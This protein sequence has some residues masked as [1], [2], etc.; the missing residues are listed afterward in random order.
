[1]SVTFARGFAASGVA[2][3]LK[4]NGNLD[5]ALVVNRGP[6]EAAAAVFTTNRAKANPIIWSQRAVAD[7]RARAVLLNSG[8]ANCYT[9]AEGFQTTHHSAERVAHLLELSAADV[10]VCSTGM[11]G[12]QLDRHAVLEGIELAVGALSED[13]SLNPA[14]AIMTTDSVPK[15]ATRESRTGWRIG[16]IAKG[17]GMLAPN[18]ATMLVVITTDAAV[19]ADDLQPALEQAVRVTFNRLDA[20]GCTSTNDQVTLL[21]SGRSGLAPEADDF[22]ELLTELCRDLAEQLIADAEGASHTIRIRVAGAATESDAEAIARTL[23]RNSLFKTAIYGND[24]NWGRILAAI[25]VA[26]VDFDPMAVSVSINGVRIAANG[27]PDADPATV[28][29]TQREVRIDIELASGSAEIELLTNDLTE[30][31]VVENSA[32]SS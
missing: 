16:G 17:A 14:L 1:M 28:D 27:A 6:N 11:I 23:A 15:H 2:A 21:A 32:Y 3:G 22:Q 31:Y 8:G 30:K 29:L 19:A 18:L 5:L 9:G 12:V 4:S 26:P 24:P 20:D 13:D 25:G 7:G 10:L